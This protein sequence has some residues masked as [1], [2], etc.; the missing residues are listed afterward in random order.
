[1]EYLLCNCDSDDTRAN[2]FAV[3]RSDGSDQGSGDDGELHGFL[4]DRRMG[5][6]M[7]DY[8]WIGIELKQEV[9]T[10]VRVV[11]GVAN[12]SRTENYCSSCMECRRVCL[13]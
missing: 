11:E 7:K 4:F 1:M 13:I 5:W 6:I 8:F 9:K 12:S 3:L 10:V 2:F